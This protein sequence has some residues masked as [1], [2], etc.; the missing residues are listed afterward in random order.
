MQISSS[1]SVT[2]S[3]KPT[4]AEMLNDVQHLSPWVKALAK[5]YKEHPHEPVLAREF[6][7]KLAGKEA[8]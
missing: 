3:S 8:K 4:L 7:E 5:G 2:N 6:A 1:Q